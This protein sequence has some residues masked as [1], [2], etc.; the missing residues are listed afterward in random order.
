[1]HLAE[2]GCP[3]VGDELYGKPNDGC[4][5]GLRA[6]RLAYPDPFSRRHVVIRAPVEEFYAEYGFEWKS[7]AVG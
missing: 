5:L 3:V 4:A 2:S 6:V 7:R 1:V